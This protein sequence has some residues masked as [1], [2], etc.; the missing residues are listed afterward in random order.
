MKTKIDFLALIAII[1]TIFGIV[2]SFL[3]DFRNAAGI[4]SV[5]AMI[6]WLRVV[7]IECK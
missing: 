6:L 3:Q 2:F 5:T 7:M 1:L 4:W